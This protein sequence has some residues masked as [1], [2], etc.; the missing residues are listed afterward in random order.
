[1][2]GRP[3]RYVLMTMGEDILKTEALPVNLMEFVD[4]NK[5]ACD[6]FFIYLYKSDVFDLILCM[7]CFKGR[8]LSLVSD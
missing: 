7:F 2:A 8:V 1:M 6:L 4:G 5:E 3:V